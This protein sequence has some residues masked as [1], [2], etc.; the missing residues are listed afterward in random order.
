ML[1]QLKS[2]VHRLGPNLI[3]FASEAV[4]YV[5]IF[6]RLFQMYLECCTGTLELCGNSNEEQ[7]EKEIRVE[8]K[9]EI[10]FRHWHI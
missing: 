6:Y 7:M 1:V 9:K 4:E 2:R 5:M 10:V 8:E 3:D